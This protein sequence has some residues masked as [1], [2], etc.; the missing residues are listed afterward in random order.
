MK[1]TTTKQAVEKLCKELKEDEGYYIVWKANIAM[2]FKD[3]FYRTY[4][5]NELAEIHNIANNA[6]DNFLKLLMS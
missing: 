3:E 2:A 4:P 1:N 6:A 5:E